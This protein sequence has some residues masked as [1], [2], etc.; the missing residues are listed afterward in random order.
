MD[1][2][3]SSNF[4]F[5][6]AC[7]VIRK[8]QFKIITLQ[9]PDEL[10][11][12]CV[13]IYES[14]YNELNIDLNTDYSLFIAVDSAYGS[15]IDDVSALHIESHL[16]VYFGSDLSSSGSIPVIVLPQIKPIAVKSC[17]EKVATS[18]ISANRISISKSSNKFISLAI[19]YD[20]SHSH[21]I[22]EICSSL[23]SKLSLLLTGNKFNIT[24]AALPP[25]ADLNNWNKDFVLG[26]SQC[27]VGGLIIDKSL[28]SPDEREGTSRIMS[29]I[30]YIGDK[31]EQLQSI[32]LL[33]SQKLH[34]CYSPSSDSV[35]CLYGYESREFTQ[36]TGGMLKVKEANTIGIIIGSM[37]LTG[38]NTQLIVKRLQLLIEASGRKHYTFAMGRL[39]EAKLSNFPEID[40]FC[41]ISNDDSSMIASK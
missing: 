8:N 17:V 18:I 25:C 15:S 27:L 2:S 39:N 28:L 16:I 33:L 6:Q 30:I 40:I 31:K 4:F 5:Q 1:S 36:R 26:P 7:N 23:T 13:D 38:E 11:T 35:S 32:S 14:F 41:L 22:K 12:H 29:V 10:S 37:G 9:F 21:D 20:P 34:I 3:F 24:A 19:L